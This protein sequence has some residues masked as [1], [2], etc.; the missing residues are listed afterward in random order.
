MGEPR[1]ETGQNHKKFSTFEIVD[2]EMNVRNYYS[3]SCGENERMEKRDIDFLVEKDPNRTM[4]LAKKNNLK[5]LFDA[6]GRSNNETSANRK[7][8]SYNNIKASFKN[9]NWYNN[10]WV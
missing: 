8:W 4:E 9:F 10:G 5:L 2:A 3:I 6:K 1:V 7:D